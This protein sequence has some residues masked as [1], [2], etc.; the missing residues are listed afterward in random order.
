MA[1]GVNVRLPE[2]LREFVEE[3]SSGLYG[4]VSEYIRELV[5]RDYEAEEARKWSGLRGEITPGL[6]A[7]DHEFETVSAEDVIARNRR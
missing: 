2:K 6:L 3:R 5:R 1:E 7:G 4:S